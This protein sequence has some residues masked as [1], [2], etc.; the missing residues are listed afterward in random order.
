MVQ[1]LIAAGYKSD[2]LVEEIM[3]LT[4]LS[5]SDARMVIAIETGTV[6]GDTEPP[7]HG[8]MFDRLKRSAGVANPAAA[9]G[10]TRRR[11]VP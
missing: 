4:G 11:S 2:A 6:E 1:E 3:R 5:L 8:S 7:A 10:V 9:D